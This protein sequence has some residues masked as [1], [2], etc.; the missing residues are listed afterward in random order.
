MVAMTDAKLI[1][2]LS[3]ASSL[4][5]FELSCVID[6]LLADPR[7]IVAVRNKLNLGKSVR[8]MDW[9]TGQMRSGK[10]VA[11][12]DSQVSVHEDGTRSQWK[13]SYAAIDP[14][15]DCEPLESTAAAAPA[16][17]T[18]RKPARDDFCRGDKVSFTDKYL[19]PQVG[20]VT[21]INQRTA[22][23]ECESGSA[24]RVPFAML[25]HVMDI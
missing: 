9:R 3:N 21:R 22:S 19:Q 4:E 14:G 5:L 25:S 2:T 13:L 1:E 18:V 12:K 8:F 16:Q 23:V 17:P 10:V 6:R 11:I 7:R 15:E 24:W 20:T